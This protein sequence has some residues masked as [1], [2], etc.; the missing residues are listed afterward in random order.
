MVLQ[1]I[2][3]G[4][5]PKTSC[6]TFQDKVKSWLNAAL[7]KEEKSWL[8]GGT[9]EFI[10]QYCFSPLAMDVIQVSRHLGCWG[11]GGGGVQQL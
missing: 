5:S 3:S 11:Q 4:T 1:Q 9:P 6:F 2:L 7:R 8:N 10:E